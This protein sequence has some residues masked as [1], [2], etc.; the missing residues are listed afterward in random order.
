MRGKPSP[1]LSGIL[2]ACDPTSEA[3]LGFRSRAFCSYNDEATPE[4]PHRLRG[5]TTR[6]L[7]TEDGL[8]DAPG[9]SQRRQGVPV[10]LTVRATSVPVTA[11]LTGP[12]RT[13]TDNAEAASTCAVRCHSR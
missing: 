1:R 12:Q 7:V 9:W 6:W 2:A 3:P 5:L 8:P 13:T 4:L 10:A 11:V